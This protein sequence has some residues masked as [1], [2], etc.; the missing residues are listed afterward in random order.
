M[1]DIFISYSKNDKPVV[2]ILAA[3]LHEDG[4]DVFWDRKIEAGA[5]WNDEIQR[6]I[7]NARCVL[8]VWSKASRESFW[9]QGEA[10]EAYA[11]D[12]YVPIKIDDTNPPRLFR[13]VQA[14]SVSAWVRSGSTEDLDGLRQSIKSRIGKLEMYGTLEK[15]SDGQP[16]SSVHLHLIHSCWRIDKESKFGRMPYQIHL[17]VFGHHSA[18]SRIKSVEYRLPGYPDGH[19][20]QKGGPADR[21]FELKELANGFS[22]A[23]ADVHLSSQPAGHP[24][25]IRLSRLINMS[26]SG[27]RLLDDFVRRQT[28]NS[29]FAEILKS[30]PA[31]EE[32]AIRLM[33]TLDREEVA[34]RLTTDGYRKAMVDS[35]IAT[36]EARFR[37]SK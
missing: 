7:Q 28:P 17:I 11:R 31:A 37:R 3:C 16:V 30:L 29:R 5:D 26:E 10:A 21:L 4:W 34:R 15:V 25:V 20:S 24:K 13:H 36:A 27:P 18:L 8:V 14:H 33:A 12:T 32:E 19:H 9:V 23:Q 22:I 6:E 1:T 35:A 2:E